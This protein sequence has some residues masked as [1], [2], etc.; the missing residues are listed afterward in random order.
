MSRVIFNNSPAVPAFNPVRADIAFFVGLV[1]LLPGA[2][3]A[4]ST[5]SWLSSL[6]YSSGPAPY[7]N[8]IATLTNIPIPINSY[9]EFTA[10]FDDGSTGTGYGTDYLATAVRS[11][12]SQGGRK[13]YVVRVDDPVTPTDTAQ[14]KATKLQELLP[15]NTFAPDQAQSWTGVGSLSVLEDASYLVTPDLPILCA[16]DSDGATGQ[17]P[18]PASGPEEFVVCSKG[19]ITPQQYR[20]FP[21]PAPRLSSADYVGWAASVATILNYLA[22]GVTSNQLHLREIQYVAAFPMPQDLDPATAAENPSSAEI[23]QDIHDVIASQMPE[24]VIAPGMVPAGNISSSFLQ[25]TYPWLK[26]SGSGI[27]LESLQPPDGP[28]AGLLARNALTRGAFTSAT[29][30]TPAEIYDVL[31]ALPAKEMLSSAQPLV[32]G[33]NPV[34]PK[35]LIER[36]SL[37]GFTPSGL[38]LLSDVTAYPGESYRSAPVNRLVSVI[39]RA[40]RQMGES[41]VFQNNGPALWGRVQRF[42]QNLMTRLWTLNALDGDTASDAFSVRCDKTTMTQNDL[43]NGR[44]IAYVTFNAASTIETITVQL[45]METSGTS[46]QQI[47]ANLAEAS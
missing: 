18:N 4:A 14:S 1:R 25:L 39:C 45:A 21:S 30:I 26:T 36:L 32:W 7:P 9:V 40:A 41:A 35:A 28:L 11:F 29:K 46:V 44:M 15:N 43:D 24:I 12:F 8:Q 19:D 27:L 13:C 3:V 17:V 37:F 42:L 47:T 38:R 31:P 16:S 20:T 2:A 33:A 22:S 5:A 34:Q 10:L 23:A 6:G